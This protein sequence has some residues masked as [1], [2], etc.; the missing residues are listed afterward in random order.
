[1]KILG[2]DR[3]HSLEVAEVG[4]EHGHL[5]RGCHVSFGETRPRDGHATGG[6]LNTRTISFLVTLRRYL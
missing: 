1:M 5:D 4:E 2:I 3:V 6:Q